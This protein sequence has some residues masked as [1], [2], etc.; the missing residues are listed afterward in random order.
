[1]IKVRVQGT[2]REI[3]WFLKL[4][5]RDKRFR[6]ENTST[7]FNNKGTDKYKRL[8]T[9]VHRTQDEKEISLQKRNRRT[10]EHRNTGI[11][12]ASGRVFGSYDN[13]TN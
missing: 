12:C 1:M 10:S 7:F 13:V 4:L 6:L 2:K 9:E 5:E 8:Y 3:R 11:A